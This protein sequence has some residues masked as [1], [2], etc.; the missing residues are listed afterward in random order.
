MVA[1]GLINYVIG[2]MV[3]GKKFLRTSWAL[4]ALVTLE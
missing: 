1:K 2:M 4:R 3:Q